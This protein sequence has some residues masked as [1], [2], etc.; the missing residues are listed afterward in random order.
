MATV[1]G[2]ASGAHHWTAQAEAL[3]PRLQQYFYNPG[4]GGGTGGS[5]G[6]G[7]WFQDKH[8]NGSF[9]PIQGCEGYAALFAGVATPRQAQAVAA[10]LADPRKFLL[11]F[12]L[13]TVSL[14]NP[15]Y[16]EVSKAPSFCCASARV[17]L[18][19]T[20]PFLAVCLPVCPSSTAT[21]KARPGWTRP[22][23]HTPGCGTT[24]PSVPAAAAVSTWRGSLARSSTGR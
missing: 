10:T 18:S 23:S 6:G 21:G 24:P 13:P 16:I 12:S 7:G 11:N 9:L 15:G 17:V 5:G 3:L 22:G 2:N 20:V 19:K 1:L 14:A 4:T 8:F